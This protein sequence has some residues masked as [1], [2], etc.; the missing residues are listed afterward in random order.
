M[1]IGKY[2]YVYLEIER[3]NNKLKQNPTINRIKEI[4]AEKRVQEDSL[5]LV[6]ELQSLKSI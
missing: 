5:K 1:Q 4:M 6:D 3:I 2:C